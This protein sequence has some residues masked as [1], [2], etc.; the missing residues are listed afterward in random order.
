M[1]KELITHN[2]T[3]THEVELPPTDLPDTDG[4]PLE[5]AW[6]RACMN[7]LIEAVEVRL[8]GRKD[9]YVG[10]NM[11][12]YYS[13]QQA[14]N[15]DYNGP[16]FFFVHGPGIDHDRPRRYWAVWDENG[17]YPDVIIE[18]SSPSTAKEDHTT[19]KDLYER[20][21]QTKEYFIYDPFTR[22]LEGWRLTRQR[23]RRIKPNEL[24][25]M[26]CEQLGLWVGTW[27]GEF[28]GH[29][30][31]WLRFYD[32][33]GNVVPIG[34]ELERQ[35]AQAAEAE[36]ARLRQ[37]RDTRNGAGGQRRSRRKRD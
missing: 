31:L 12:I 27:Q 13:A 33:E 3:Y 2:I 16:D 30:D 35:R 34:W 4:Q 18:L 15:R 14:R 20:T 26:W 17:R 23:Y 28:Q 32:P 8:A 37:Q 21:F 11:F 19:R 22:V 5:S 7:L 24:G 6:H 25:R 1:P 9:F 36:L 29:E 10:G